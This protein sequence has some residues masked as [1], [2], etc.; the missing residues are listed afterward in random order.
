MEK[1][2]GTVRVGYGTV[3]FFLKK[4]LVQYKTVRYGSVVRTTC[5]TVPGSRG[6]LLV[7]WY[8][9]VVLPLP[10]DNTSC[11]SILCTFPIYPL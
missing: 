10:P 5:T 9:L 3:V 8:P 7:Q 1:V 6:Y 4:V 11:I 2:Y